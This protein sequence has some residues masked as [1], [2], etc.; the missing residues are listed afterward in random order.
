MFFL[1]QISFYDEGIALDV[2]GRTEGDQFSKIEYRHLQ[3]HPH[4]KFHIMLNQANGIATVVDLY[5]FAH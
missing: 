5:D 2:I 4:D 3:T 1:S